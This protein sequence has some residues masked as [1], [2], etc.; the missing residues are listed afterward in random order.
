MK[1]LI[2]TIAFLLTSCGTA[3]Q[4]ATMK[5]ELDR[6]QREAAQQET[7]LKAQMEEQEQYAL[8]QID[9]A[10][11]VA[12]DILNDLTATEQALKQARQQ[13]IPPPRTVIKREVHEV[14]V[15]VMDGS[16]TREQERELQQVI[17]AHRAR[18]RN[19]Q[20]EVRAIQA[21]LRQTLDEL[22]ALRN[23]GPLERHA[24]GGLVGSIFGMLVTL[25]GVYVRRWLQPIS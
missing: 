6:Q 13:P 25:A 10:Q 8:E 15:E 24:A 3:P 11:N 5:A 22:M 1:A 12:Q 18:I 19:Q 7:N 23:Q 16:L 14:P 9:N 4:L 21:R 20:N 2:L 17:D